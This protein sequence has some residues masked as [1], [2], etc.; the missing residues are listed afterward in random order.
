[1]LTSEQQQEFHETGFVRIRGAFSCEQAALMEDRLWDVLR[2]KHGV[3][4]DDPATWQI[5]LAVGLQKIRTEKVFDPIGGPAMTEALDGLI[6]RER[7]EP[8]KHWGQFLVTFPVQGE[9]WAV[10]TRIWHTDFPYWVPPDRVSGVVAFS[11]LSKVPARSGGTLVIAGSPRVVERFIQERPKLRRAKMKV[12]RHAL[13]ATDPWLSDLIEKNRPNGRAADP[14]DEADS[15][16][17][18]LMQ[19]GHAI[20]GM[21][22]HVAELTGEPGDVI[23][24]HPWLLHCPGPNCGDQPRFMRVQR[25]RARS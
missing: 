5:P 2:S 16:A 25:I 11:F 20:D 18:R 14:G 17:D 15:R 13:F 12:A 10:P 23:L 6:G 1:M 4:R 24:G 19:A 8:P 7:W 9:Q 3:Q 22:V 21:P